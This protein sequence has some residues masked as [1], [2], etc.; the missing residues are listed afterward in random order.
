MRNLGNRVLNSLRI[1][2]YSEGDFQ[3]RNMYPK[4]AFPSPVIIGTD[5]ATD[6]GGTASC[7]IML[8]SSVKAAQ[9]T[10]REEV[11]MFVCPV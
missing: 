7:L 10:R 9:R 6:F 11:T 5:D 8:L 3:W 1:N 4:S 2:N